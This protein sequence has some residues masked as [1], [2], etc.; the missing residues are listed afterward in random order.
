MISRHGWRLF[1]FRA[2]EKSI[3]EAR[4]YEDC[5]VIKGDN[6]YSFPVYFVGYH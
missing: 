5:V 6:Y 1:G 3:Y 2:C 4:V